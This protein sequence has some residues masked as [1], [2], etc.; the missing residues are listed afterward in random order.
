[1]LEKQTYRDHETFLALQ[2]KNQNSKTALWKHQDCKMHITAKKRDCEI[3]EIWQK[4]GQFLK[5]H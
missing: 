2:K 3:R 1:M 5:D 4:S